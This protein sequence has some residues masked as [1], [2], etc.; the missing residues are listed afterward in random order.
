MTEED[1]E[2]LIEVKAMLTSGAWGNT[3]SIAPLIG[4]T[5]QWYHGRTV[6]LTRG[7]HVINVIAVSTSIYEKWEHVFDLTCFDLVEDK[8][9]VYFHSAF[10][11]TDY[12][13][14][15]NMLINWAKGYYEQRMKEEL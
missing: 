12:D 5:K 11:C 1:R 6:K 13:F 10:S 8:I 3:H 9:L 2:L 7:P 4:S 15:L 14:K